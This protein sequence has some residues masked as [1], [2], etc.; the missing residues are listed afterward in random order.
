MELFSLGKQV[1]SKFVC[2]QYVCGYTLDYTR[3]VLLTLS[4]HLLK[5]LLQFHSH[6]KRTTL[7]ISHKLFLFQ[8]YVN[9]N[10]LARF[11]KIICEL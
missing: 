6:E 1:F 8:G 9:F 7:R 11:F 4:S 3:L 5:I 10:I 2:I